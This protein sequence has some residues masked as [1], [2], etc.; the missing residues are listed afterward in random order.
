MTNI[1][2]NHRYITKHDK[3]R[4][5][6][7]WFFKIFAR[8]DVS[9]TT[10]EIFSIILNFVDR[11]TKWRAYQKIEPLDSTIFL[12]IVSLEISSRTNHNWSGVRRDYSN[13]FTYAKTAMSKLRRRILIRSICS[14][15]NTWVVIASAT[16]CE[17]L[18]LIIPKIGIKICAANNI[19]QLTI[20][21]GFL[22]ICFRI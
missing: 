5:R 13:P 3:R 18:L 19:K 1:L 14:A 17:L 8:D 4:N 21:H 2:Y 10:I 16:S 22:I 7:N 12:S 11:C 6:Y 15:R 9:L 20:K